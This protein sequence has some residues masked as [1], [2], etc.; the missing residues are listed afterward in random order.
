MSFRYN[1]HANNECAKTQKYFH[2]QQCQ[3]PIC[4]RTQAQNNAKEE[5]TDIQYILFRRKSMIHTYI[6]KEIKRCVNY[7]LLNN[8]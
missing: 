5:K 6:R 4:T 2:M 1:M 8:W 7:S 3:I